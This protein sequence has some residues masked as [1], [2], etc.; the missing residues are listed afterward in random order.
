MIF[1]DRIEAGEKLA[2]KVIEVV[3]KND[4]GVVL[5]VPRGGV[6]IAKIIAEELNWELGVI[7]AKKIGFPGRGELAMG[8][9]AEDGEPIWSKD[10]IKGY[11]VKE[12]DRLRELEK[13]KRKIKDY[14]KN[15]RQGKKLEVKDKVV[16]IADDGIATGKTVEAGIKSLR[17]LKAKMVIVVVPVCA[18]DTEKR[19]RKIADKFVCLHSS[20]NFMAVG[21]F[22]KDFPQVSDE[23]VERLLVE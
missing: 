8:A 11:G 12:K 17:E 13:A 19:L 10:L 9:V 16:I 2:E 6:V 7:I 21:Q 18:K 5:G 1:T 14:I 15:F 22:Y 3:D 20:G 4:K 23:E